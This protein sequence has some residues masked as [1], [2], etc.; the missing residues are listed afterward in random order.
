MDVR[1]LAGESFKVSKES[2]LLGHF[3]EEFLVFELNCSYA[4]RSFDYFTTCP[5][6]VRGVNL[7]LGSMKKQEV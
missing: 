4:L 1:V 7:I 6:E 2:V 5:T 3:L